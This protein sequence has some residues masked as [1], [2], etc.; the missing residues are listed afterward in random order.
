MLAGLIG[1]GRELLDRPRNGILEAGALLSDPALELRCP[2]EIEPVQKDAGGEGIHR[3]ESPRSQ[4]VLE[5]T[6]LAGNGGLEA[7]LGTPNNPIASGVPFHGV[8]GLRQGMAGL[9]L[10]G[11]GPEDADQPVAADSP[12]A[13][14][15]NQGEER[16]APR[17]EGRGT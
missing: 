14:R 10:L 3:F 17:P 11:V 2:G 12:S 16:E 4:G 5:L 9:V 7:E 6:D 15:C 13:C 8:N 1:A